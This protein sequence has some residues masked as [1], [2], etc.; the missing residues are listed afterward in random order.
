MHKLVLGVLIILAIASVVFEGFK[1]KPIYQVGQR[2]KISAR[3]NSQPVNYWGGEVR[4]VVAGIQVRGK[5]VSVNEGEKV[6]VVGRVKERVIDE[7]SSNKWLEIEELTIISPQNKWRGEL[8]RVRE[9]VISSILRLIPGEE[10]VL[11]TGIVWGDTRNF[12]S[13]MREDFRNAGLSHIVAASGFNVTLLAMW[14]S[15]ISARLF[16][17][18]FTI[19]IVILSICLY[20]FLAGWTIPIIRAGLMSFIG[21]FAA[22]FG[23]QAKA[24]HTLVY[25]V[26]ILLIIKPEWLWQVS[27]QLSVMAT[28]ALIVS[29]K[30]V[31]KLFVSDLRT[32]VWVYAFTVP[33]TVGMFGTVNPWGIVSNVLILWIVPMVTQ[34]GMITSLVNLVWG[35]G[36]T[37]LGY[38]LVI[39]LKYIL[40]VAQMVANLPF[41]EFEVGK[42]SYILIIS[43][44][45]GLGGYLYRRGM[46]KNV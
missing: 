39:P 44:Y 34:L 46:R 23:R 22:L 32:T 12:T 10:G 38:L 25:V 4:F 41:A 29:G 3:V 28:L 1:S 15:M 26:V 5:D 42:V 31:E 9:W 20:M 7:N 40:E 16:S 35:V 19:Y 13:Q 8:N 36:A 24:L 11:L 43:Y 45:L 2:Y 30:G 37:I 17:K 33:I 27:F 21:V 18:K 14:I 6:E